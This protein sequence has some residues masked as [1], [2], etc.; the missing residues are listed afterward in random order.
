MGRMRKRTSRKQQMERTRSNGTVC[1]S[2]DGFAA[3][4]YHRYIYSK[5]GLNVEH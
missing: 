2:S 4:H 5:V 1:Q 3:E